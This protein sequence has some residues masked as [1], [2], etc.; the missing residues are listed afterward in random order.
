MSNPNI[1]SRRKAL[2]ADPGASGGARTAREAQPTP[3]SHETADR[4]YRG[5]LGS[6]SSSPGGSARRGYGQPGTAQFMTWCPPQEHGAQSCGS[7]PATRPV[8]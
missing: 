6:Q 3:G 7:R 4:S 8:G 5:T 2:D 1:D